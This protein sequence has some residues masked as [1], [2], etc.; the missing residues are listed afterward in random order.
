MILLFIELTVDSSKSKA[1]SHPTGS[2]VGHFPC[3][4]FHIFP[5]SKYY[6]LF[7]KIRYILFMS[8]FFSEISLG[9]L[10]VTSFNGWELD[11]QIREEYF[12]L[13]RRFWV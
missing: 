2:K 1:G 3:I 12:L 13:G 6:L 4:Y 7:L 9:G 5:P 8:V 11:K 10:N